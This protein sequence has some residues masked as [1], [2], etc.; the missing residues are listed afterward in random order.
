[1]VELTARRAILLAVLGLTALVG[2]NPTEGDG[3]TLTESRTVSDAFEGVRVSDGLTVEVR[4]SPDNTGVI[5]VTSDT[6]LVPIILTEVIDGVLE[7]SADNIAPTVATSV[8]VTAPT[9]GSI[10]VADEG[11]LVTL[12]DLAR[13][14]EGRD[15]ELAVNVSEGA[16]IEVTG[17]CRNLRAIVTGPSSLRA[18]GLTCET[19]EIEMLQD[20][21]VEARVTERAVIRAAGEGTVRLTGSPE[22]TS[23]VTDGVTVEVE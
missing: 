15:G 14:G 5:E 2:C 17:T 6:N 13:A 16:A 12:S 3:V 1:M 11:G 21:L 9:L 22:V 8:T 7:V 20:A 4:L 19:A 10:S 18:A 23:E